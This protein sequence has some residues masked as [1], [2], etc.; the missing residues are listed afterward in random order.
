[1]FVFGRK[2][3]GLFISAENPLLAAEAKHIAYTF[4]C[5]MATFLPVL[6]LLYVYLSALQGMGYSFHAVLSGVAELF[7]RWLCGALAVG[8]LGFFGICIANPAAWL[9]ATIYC[10]VLVMYYLRKRLRGEYEA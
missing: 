3:T 5:I 9:M 10:S 1:M 8:G 7:G 2:I 4:L 6:Y